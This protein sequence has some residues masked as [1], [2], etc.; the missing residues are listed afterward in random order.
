M[1]TAAAPE[2]NDL[3][4][5]AREWYDAGYCVIPAHE[6]GTKRP[7]GPWLQYQYARPAWAEIEEWLAAMPAPHSRRPIREK[8]DAESSS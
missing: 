2:P 6:D 4:A 5:A 1:T 8:T 7:F 3:L